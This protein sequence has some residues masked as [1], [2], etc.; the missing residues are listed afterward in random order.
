VLILY[1]LTPQSLKLADH[2][3]QVRNATAIL[4]VGRQFHKYK[5]KIWII[6]HES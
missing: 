6:Y 2:C 5:P 3:F 1:L 4:S